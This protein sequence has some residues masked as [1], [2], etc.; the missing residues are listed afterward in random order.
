MKWEVRRRY[1]EFLSL[2]EKLVDVGVDK[3]GLPPKKIL[4]NKDPAFLIKRRKELETYLQSTFHF[5]EKN[6]P[7]VLADFLYFDKVLTIF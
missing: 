4:G 7:T 6:V 1:N 5:L 2:H 3:D